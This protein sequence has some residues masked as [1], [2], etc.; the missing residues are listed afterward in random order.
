MVGRRAAHAAAR[1]GRRAATAGAARAGDAE[2][3]AAGATALAG[4]SGQ[5]CDPAVAGLSGAIARQARR[6]VVAH[7]LVTE[8]TAPRHPAVPGPRDGQATGR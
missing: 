5:L 1:P 8:L 2:G 6:G 4:S 3:P 7:A